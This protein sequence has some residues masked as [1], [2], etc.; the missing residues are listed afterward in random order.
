MKFVPETGFNISIVGQWNPSIFSPSWVRANIVSDESE[1][2]FAVAISDPA[3]PPRI[4]FSTTYLFPSRQLLDFR[5][6]E[7]TLEA[8]SS[9]GEAA[10]KIVGL[11]PHTP[12]SAI[13]INFRFIEEENFE[14]AASLFQ[15]NDSAKIPHE[16]YSLQASTV[17]RSF[18]MPGG[19]KLNLSLNN[20]RCP[21]SGGL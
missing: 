11:L 18:L 10:S 4:S 15:F 20:T 19:D 6:S 8:F 1:V 7:M 21:S 3:A 5:A 16:K 9:C 12:I 14:K 13:G 2:L 17:T